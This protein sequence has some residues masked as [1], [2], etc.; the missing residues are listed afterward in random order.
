MADRQ[1]RIS[2]RPAE[3]EHA[4]PV[5]E[6]LFGM[7]IKARQEFDLPG[8]GTMVDGVIKDEDLDAVCAG[9]GGRG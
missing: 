9:E 4:E 8:A 1:E 5:G 2:I 3:C 7:V 6:Y